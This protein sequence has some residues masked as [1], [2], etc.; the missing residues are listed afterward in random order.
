MLSQ[1]Q[2][3]GTALTSWRRQ[4]TSAIL[5][6]HYEWIVLGQWPARDPSL[7]FVEFVGR[8]GVTQSRKDASL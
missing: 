2:M 7:G 6:R 8:P 4:L 3:A 1:V 5:A